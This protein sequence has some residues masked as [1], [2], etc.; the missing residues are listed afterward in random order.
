MMAFACEN[1]AAEPGAPISFQNVLDGIEAPDFPA[2][3]A[4]WFA[5]FC[6]YSSQEGTIP[7][8]RVVIS[9]ESGEAVAQ[10]AVKDLRFTASSP[11]SR[12]MVAFGGLAWPYP[13]WYY[14]KF[15]A[16]RDSLLAVF[17]MWVQH[18]PAA[19]DQAPADTVE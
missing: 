6:F 11:I 16:E 1:V 10:T 15:I 14:V 19:E 9:H 3:T 18:A 12:N 7:N 8:C 5:I 17:P 4:R 2:P 13:G